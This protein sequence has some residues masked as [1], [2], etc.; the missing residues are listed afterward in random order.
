MG[1]PNTSIVDFVICQF[2]VKTCNVLEGDTLCH[3][4]SA[5][6]DIIQFPRL[7]TIKSQDNG[8]YRYCAHM[9]AI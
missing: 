5:M 9:N 4:M 6:Y 1:F 3:S 8:D 7:E 2:F